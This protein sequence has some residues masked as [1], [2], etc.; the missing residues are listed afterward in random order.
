M[1]T[2]SIME[3]FLF[4][5]IYCFLGWCF[6]S[7]YVSIKSKKFINRGFLKGPFLP[8][9]GT[10]AI[11]VL[12]VA[13]PFSGN[14]PGVFLVGALAATV[15]EYVTGVLMEAVFKV[16]YWDYSNQKLNF[17]GHVCASST[18]AWGFLSIALI[19][20]LHRGVEK[21]L[22]FLPAGME[23]PMTLVLTVFIVAD[24]TLSFKD[25]LELR[26]IL[27]KMELL[28]KELKRIQ[29]RLEQIEE[30]IAETAEQ[31]KEQMKEQFKEE[32]I[33]IRAKQMYL[34]DKAKDRFSPYWTSL[35]KRNPTAKTRRY[36]SVLTDIKERLLDKKDQ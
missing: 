11:T 12:F 6:E 29:K 35:I 16:R 2:Y 9:Y 31:K 4:F 5:Y 33:D 34:T 1:H 17:Q 21:V 23:K 25:A 20:G 26:S 30:T 36:A 8:I 19:F 3:W 24:V 27:G 28:V 10:G 7:A 14:I 18:V 32:L 15:L 22:S 13:L